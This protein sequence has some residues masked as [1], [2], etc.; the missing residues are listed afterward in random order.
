MSKT[1]INGQPD[2]QINAPSNPRVRESGQGKEDFESYWRRNKVRLW[3]CGYSYLQA[4]K[5]AW[6]EWTTVNKQNEI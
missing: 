5:I 6:K 1:T 4:R 2:A 3:A